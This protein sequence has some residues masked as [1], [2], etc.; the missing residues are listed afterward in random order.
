MTNTI[1]QGTAAAQQ[2]IKLDGETRPWISE[3]EFVKRFLLTLH[4]YHKGEEVNIYHWLNGVKEDGGII[5]AT[6][7]Q[8]VRL[9]NQ[10]GVTVGYVPPILLDP[11]G[12]LPPEVTASLADIFYRAEN[13]DNI[14]PGRGAKFIDEQ[15]TSQVKTK[16]E[17]AKLWKEAWDKLFV[18]YGLDPVYSEAV[19]D[20][21]TQVLAD[22][23]EGEYEDVEYL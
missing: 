17:D 16:E 18:K 19:D 5:G 21:E 14:Y 20:P 10:A 11:Q 1:E 7:F 4:S 8:S 15:I 3:N 12:V 6:V 13:L 23:E 2:I 9:D 22:E